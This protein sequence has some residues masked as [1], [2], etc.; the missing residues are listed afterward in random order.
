MMDSEILISLIK[1]Q[2]Q[3]RETRDRL[4]EMLEQWEV[5]HDREDSAWWHGYPDNSSAVQEED[6]PDNNGRGNPGV[7]SVQG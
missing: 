7:S 6:R 3:L 4:A 2:R 1:A 5:G